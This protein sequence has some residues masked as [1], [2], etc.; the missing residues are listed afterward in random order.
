MDRIF[1]GVKELASKM[2]V[3]EKTIYRML[4]DNQFPFAVKIGG[5][6]RFRADSVTKWIS[7]QTGEDKSEGSINYKITV[8][9]ALANGS[10]LYRIQ[11]SN[12][13]EALDELL[14]TLP[15]TGTFNL[16]DFKFSILEKEALV[17]SSLAGVACMSPSAEHP[18]FLERSIIILAFLEQPTDFKAL[19]RIPAQAIFLLLPSNN[20]ELAIL[21]TR[22]Q[23]LIMDPIFISELLKEP[24]RK[25][26]LEY[27]RETENRLLFQ[28][29]ATP[30]KK[31]TNKK[32][33]GKKAA[34]S[35]VQKNRS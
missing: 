14:S 10:V 3:S 21:Q 27:I 26:L 22:L 13:D 19:D 15:Q 18:V 9:D 20:Q 11:G 17:P 2:G 35:N 30:E 25:E 31:P 33:T 8:S 12:R 28:L 32:N 23:R 5:Q 34:G 7:L 24:S 6:W 4:N 16:N 1:I 29:P